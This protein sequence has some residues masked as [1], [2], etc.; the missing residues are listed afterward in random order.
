[1]VGSLTEAAAA[2][3]LS[4]SKTADV[5]GAAAPGDTIP[6]TIAISN[7]GTTTQSGVSVVDPV[8]TGTTYVADSVIIS[9]D[10]PVGLGGPTTVIYNASSSFVVPFGVTSVTIEAWGAGG[11]A[12]KAAGAG[13]ND[14]GGGGG[15][16]GYAR[17]IIAVTPGTPHTVRVGVGGATATAGGDTWFGSTATVFAQ[18]GLAG[19]TGTSVGAG[20][21]ANIGNQATYTGGS[22]GVGATGGQPV[23]RFG[24]GGGGSATATAAGGA[25]QAGGS[26]TGGA[27]GVGEGKGGAGTQGAVNGNPGL[28]PG[29]GGG[30]GGNTAV[31]GAGA[32]GRIIIRYVLPATAGVTNDP[33]NLASG[34]TLAPGAV[35][36]I[37]FDVTVD[38]PAMVTQVVNTASVTSTQMT[39]PR[40]DTVVTPIDVDWAQIGGLAWHDANGNGIQDPEETDGIAGIPVELVD[41]NGTVVASTDTD[42]N[43]EYLFTQLFPGTY[44]VRFDLREV[45][46]NL[47]VTEPFQGGDPALDSDVISG[48]TGE[49]AATGSILLQAGA[50]QDAINL[51]LKPLNATRAEVAEVWG[52]GRDGAG[53][54][55]WQTSSEWNTAG[56]FVYRV[57]PKTGVETL[58]NE[59]LVPSAFHAAGATYE[60][61]DSKAVAGGA[62]TYRLEEVELTGGT[63]DLGTHDVVFGAARP[64]AKVAKATLAKSLLAS[65]KLA[66]PSPILKVMVRDEGLYA[67]ALQAVADG[68]GLALE[69][70]QAVAEAGELELSAQGVAVPVLYDADQARL[71][72]H[73]RGADN[74]YARDNAYLIWRGT[75]TAMVRREPGAASGAA[76]LPVVVNFEVDQYPFDSA[77]IRPEDFYYWEYVLSATNETTT[78]VRSF[79]LELTGAA[80][81]VSL[82]VRLIGWSVTTNDPDHLAEFRFNGTPAGS[83][84]FDGQDAAVAGLAI[85]AGAVSNGVNELSVRGVLQPGRSHSYFVVDGVDAAFERAVAPIPGTA[86]FLAGGAQAVS[87]AAFAEPLAVALDADGTP[88]WLADADGALPAKAWAAAESDARFAVAEASAILL[89]AP[90]AVAALPWFLDETNRIDYLVLTSRALEAAAHELADYRAGQGLRVGVAT[91]E[92]VCDWF[93]GGLRTPEAIP[94]LFA[95]AAETWADVPWMVVLA[96]NGHYDYLDALGIEV[97]HVP[98]LLLQTSDGIFSSDG[99]LADITGDGLP[100]LAI[101]RLPALTAAELAAMVAKIRAYE[102]GFGEAWANR[103]VLATDT[104]DP[105]AGDFQASTAQFAALATATHPV[106]DVV[107]LNVTPI[108]LARTRLTNEFKAGAGFIHYTGHGGVANWSQLNLLKATD[109][110]AMTNAARPPAVVA[111]SCLVGRFEAPGV[112]SLGELLLRKAG[113]GAVA[114]WGPSG[115]S[116]NHPA[117]ELGEAFYRAVVQ[118]GS[119]TL[120]MAILRAR[121]SIDANRFNQDT[122]AIYNL[123]G[124]PA[125]RIAG[126]VAEQATDETFAQ[127]LWQRLSPADQADPYASGA[128]DDNFFEYAMGGGY[129]VRVERPEFGFPFPAPDEAGFVLRWKRRIRRADIDYRLLITENLLE[130]WQVATSGDSREIS[131]EPDLNGV[132]ETVRTRIDRPQALRIFLGIQARRK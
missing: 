128:T 62:G 67:V 132:M 34:W 20:G 16:G 117:T 96:G 83:I 98:P 8:P 2:D 87:A 10:P 102:A 82:K 7:T 93:A 91:F 44:I 54:V 66:G 51:G 73:G 1:M 120:G 126:N 65:P 28:A 61:I 9:V 36:T 5:V 92:D 127:W 75:G 86:H 3:G 81:D 107:D 69:E 41:T 101:G 78:S 100:D 111:L 108:K 47:V 35:M 72:F 104:N 23:T 90:E 13:G 84:A 43:G 97:N 18:R 63:L 76:T 31:G 123:L 17:G 85:P 88:T 50:N 11:G 57:D 79:P 106:A 37:T 42:A 118:E 40:T 12:G 110:A 59:A 115:L 26:N 95:Y 32:N 56:F 119:G 94:L 114:A 113:G 38:N 48:T 105:A 22:G 45:T 46:T 122:L 68:M 33:P 4:I 30:G 89:L 27:G 129:D 80:G 29:G 64:R 21:S 52:E 130:E 125:L 6:Y 116:R 19:G 53:V 49:W 74:W 24:G 109:V 58:L 14:A 112:N 15:G 77:A 103:I 70:V 55:V 60:W 39:Q 99:L 121:R 25:G 124:D 131:S 71:V